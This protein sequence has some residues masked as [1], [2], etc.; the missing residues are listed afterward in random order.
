MHAFNLSSAADADFSHVV[1]TTVL[2]ADIADFA[3]V[4][5]VYKEFFSPPNEPARAAYQ[6]N[7]FNI[8]EHKS[9]RKNKR[10]KKYP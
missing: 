7:A 9:G 3:K 8:L 1:K 2:L 4:N 5:E 10:R 6:V